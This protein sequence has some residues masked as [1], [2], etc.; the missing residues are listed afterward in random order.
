MG[1]QEQQ[2]YL[3]KQTE[4]S[5]H[6]LESEEI[7]RI[8]AKK[9]VLNVLENATKESLRKPKNIRKFQMFQFK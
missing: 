9:M 7:K 8:K 5:T 3:F 2:T 4:K 6:E 1:V